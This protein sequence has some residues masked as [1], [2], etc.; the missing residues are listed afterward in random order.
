MFFVD[1]FAFDADLKSIPALMSS[2]SFIDIIHD[3]KSTAQ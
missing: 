1:T 3:L 2:S